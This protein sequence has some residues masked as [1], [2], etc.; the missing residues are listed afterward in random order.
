[1]RVRK[2]A[3]GV[4]VHAIAGTYVVMLGMDAEEGAKDGLLGFA[5]ER[6]DKT[7]NEQYWLTGMRTFKSVYP[8]PPRGALVSSH[9]HPIQ[10]FLPLDVGEGDL[11]P[12]VDA[13]EAVDVA[14]PAVD[15][16]AL[17]VAGPG[18]AAALA[19]AAVALAAVADDDHVVVAELVSPDVVEEVGLFAGDDDQAAAHGS[20]SGCG[21]GELRRGRA[22]R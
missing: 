19:A 16:A 11:A 14:G 13:Q 3:G 8:N 22:R 2:M 18:G 6:I 15:A 21:G 20:L 1:M 10:D 5:I 9:A 4:S 17:V 7:E 12:A